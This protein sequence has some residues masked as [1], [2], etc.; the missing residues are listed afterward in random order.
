LLTG[1]GQAHHGEILRQASVLADDNKLRPILNQ[2][3]FSENEIAAAHALVEAGALGK[4]VVE[5]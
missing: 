5:F 2:Q 1:F 3:R 4:V